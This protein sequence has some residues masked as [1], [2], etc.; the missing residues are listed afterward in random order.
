MHA[1]VS[2]EDLLREGVEVPLDGWD[3]SWFAGRA[4]EERPS[5]GYLKLISAALARAGAALDIQTGGGEVLAEV[6]AL[7]PVTVATEQHALVTE[8]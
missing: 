4:T 8:I 5:W 1:T 6:P 7:P 2:F 3:F